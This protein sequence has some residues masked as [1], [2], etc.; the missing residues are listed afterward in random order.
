MT[1]LCGLNG[2]GKSSTVQALVVLR[3][4]FQLRA[5]QA[6]E[7]ILNGHLVKLGDGK[8]V[9]FEGA[10]TDSISIAFEENKRSFRFPV[11]YDP[12]QNSL[13]VSCPD[14]EH[15][16]SSMLFSDNF[17]YIKA[18][19]FGPT[20][21]SGKDDSAV[22]RSRSLG[23]LG[24]HVA[25]FL[26]TF[27]GEAVCNDTLIHEGA[28]DQTIKSN[29]EAWLGEI[30]PGVQVRINEH[31]GI[32]QYSSEFRFNTEEGSSRYFR[33][34]NVG[35]GVSY[36]LPIIVALV[37]A[38]PGDLVI[39]ENPEAHLHPRGQTKMGELIA[40]AA[41]TGIQ[42]LAETH[43]D[44]LLNGVRIGVKKRLLDSSKTQFHYFARSDVEHGSSSVVHSPRIDDDG[45]FSNWPD[46]FFDEW[47]KRLAELL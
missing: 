16:F 29:I 44:H 9:L 20:I 1:L 8:D 38:R 7:L 24:E 25:Q 5:L 27:G 46:G 41:S 39:L 47:E 31:S 6:N 40:R 36:S 4:S 28:Q 10:E 35:F 19:R 3:Q 33:A 37:A 45:R 14:H 23:A 26:H 30:S 2:M 32:D 18:D 43:S 15:A 13:S 17:Q 34:L 21:S 22:T 11:E 12:D 42:V